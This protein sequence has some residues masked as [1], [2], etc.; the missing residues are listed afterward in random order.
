MKH[1]LFFLFLFVSCLSYA[2]QKVIRL[3]EGKALESENWNWREQS[4]ESN[5]W[6]NTKIVYNVV[7]PSFTVFP[8]KSAVNIGTAVMIAPG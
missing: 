5:Q 3:Y 4:N 8:A 2:Q 6:N 7:E 1:H